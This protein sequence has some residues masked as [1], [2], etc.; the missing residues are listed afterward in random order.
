M[1]GFGS[2]RPSSGRPKVEEAMSL[3]VAKLFRDG[4]VRRSCK[5]EASLTWRSS[6]DQ[7]PVGSIG[8]RSWCEFGD[9]PD[10]MELNG[11]LNGN[12]FSQSIRL[13]SI[14]GTKGGKRWYA[15]C[16]VTGRRCL[17][18]VLSNRHGGWVSVRASGLRYYTE[19]EDYLGR[20]R[21]AM[22]RAEAKLKR[23]SKYARL[24]TRKRLEEEFW[25]AEDRWHEVLNHFSERFNLRLERAGLS[26]RLGQL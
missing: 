19:C 14:P 24:A 8:F 23:L 9:E 15:L 1:G 25:A 20:C 26:E 17:K 12:P 13:V 3:N 5:V 11:T 7:A 21:S 2:G 6:R 16:P 22:D 4:Y 10:R 18:L